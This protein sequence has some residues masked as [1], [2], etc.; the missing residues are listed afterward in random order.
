[1]RNLLDI[2]FFFTALSVATV[3]LSQPRTQCERVSE[4]Q[5]FEMIPARYERPIGE[6]ARLRVIKEMMI[7]IKSL[8]QAGFQ[9]L[10]SP[11]QKEL[12]QLAKEIEKAKSDASVS[13][14]LPP[15]RKRLS[16]WLDGRFIVGI[17][18]TRADGAV[19][20]FGGYAFG[21]DISYGEPAIE[22]Y[23][24]N[25]VIRQYPMRFIVPESL[26]Y[27]PTQKIGR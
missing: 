25:H 12:D 4:N 15:M 27:F 2:A 13:L 6:E 3:G 8:E 22:I 11:T 5:I 23:N 20:L 17:L 16:E 19:E 21:Y 1:M 14:D 7:N 10:S 26:Y 18:G 9:R 24:T